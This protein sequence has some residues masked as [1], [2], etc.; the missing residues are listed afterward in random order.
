MFALVRKPFFR[1][2]VI[3]LFILPMMFAGGSLV[4]GLAQD[5]VGTVESFDIPRAEFENTFQRMSEEYRRRYGIG[6]VSREL[7]A[8]IAREARDQLVTEYLMRAAADEKEIAPPPAAV[9]REIRSYEEFQNEDGEFSLE[10]Y[11]DYVPDRYRFE[12]QVRRQLGRSAIL[13][14]MESYPL[15]A[16]RER[17]AAFRRQQRVVDETSITVTAAYNIPDDDIRAY[18]D[19]NQNNYLLRERADFEYLTLSFD[20]FAKTRISVAAA[21]ITLAYEDYKAELLERR[22][23][24][25]SHIYI[26]DDSEDGY[27]RAEDLA[28][29]AAAGASF[30]DLARQY[31]DDGGTAPNG[32]AFGF[33]APGDLPEAMDDALAQMKVG[34]ISAPVEVDDGFSILRLDDSV[35]PPP[36]PLAQVRGQMTD[37]A[38]RD[39]AYDAFQAEV[40]SLREVA[41]RQVGSLLSVAALADTQV[42]RITGV[43][44]LAPPGESPQ[45]FEIQAIRE[46]AFD[47]AV[48]ANGETGAIALE[49][50]SFLFV[51]ALDYQ[52]RRARALSEVQDGIAALLNAREQVKDMLAGGEDGG[53]PDLPEDV[54]WSAPYTLNLIDEEEESLSD[55]EKRQ[56]ENID[57][58]FNADLTDGLPA[59]AMI[60]GDGEIRIF[61][62]R[63]VI[64]SPPLD[65]DFLLIDE[66]ITPAE[67]S[68]AGAGYL[69]ELSERFNVRFDIPE[70]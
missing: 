8:L 27:D 31:S 17:L 58:V 10:A 56:L 12:A 47:E 63:E 61:R 68:L 33:V 7:A 29:Q 23:Q 51:R 37:R 26:A 20:Q 46:Q 6:E 14:V 2:A 1:K 32:G 24:K 9:A 54:D 15:T 65:E 60:P 57:E 43:L 5:S 18:Y 45:P 62:I 44:R 19:A 30:A 38:R 13:A 40:E 3:V 36:K 59:F 22:R 67:R 50:D 34:D 39:L 21:D 11:E 55:E 70:R 49:D 28:E 69:A 35:S 25:V 52:P 48:V 41:F 4:E 16:V 42:R 64:N 66:L 53:A